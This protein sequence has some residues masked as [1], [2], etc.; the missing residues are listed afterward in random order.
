MTAHTPKFITL[1]G[2]EGVGKST[3]IRLLVDWLQSAGVGVCQTR[4]PGGSPG[5]EHIRDLLVKGDGDRWDPMAE[6]LLVTAARAEH[7]ARTVK[8]ALA[9]GDWVVCD[10]FSD[11]TVAYQGA[12]RELGVPEM[13][14]LQALA[15]GGF[16]PDLTI[17]LDMP[18]DV[19]LSRALGREEGKT[20]EMEDRFERLDISFHKKLRQAF[21]DIA[22][23][24]PDRCVVL[25][26]A[27]SVEDLHTALRA[28]IMARFGDLA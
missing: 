4:E 8:P 18:V 21:L 12:G 10:R 26:A 19:G 6:A 24:E 9:R 17:V 16:K 28:V 13:Q 1:E 23:A 22:V 14:A 7:V 25:D 2:G 15:L 11:S 3:Q 5:A 27:Q 20:S